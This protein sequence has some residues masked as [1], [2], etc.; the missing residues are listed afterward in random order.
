MEGPGVLLGSIQISWLKPILL[1]SQFHLGSFSFCRNYAVAIPSQL[2]YPFSEKV[3]L[4][5]SRKEAVPIH[6]AVTL[7]SKAENQTLIT[8]SISQLTFFHCTS[9]QVRRRFSRVVNEVAFIVITF[10]EASSEFQ[11]KQKVLI[12]HVDKKTFIQTDKPVYKPGQIGMD[13][14]PCLMRERKMLRPQHMG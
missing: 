7:E 11:K 10:L 8:Q 1:R 13:R 5:L 14:I 9:F 6:V 3:C 2:Y 4:Q 12:K